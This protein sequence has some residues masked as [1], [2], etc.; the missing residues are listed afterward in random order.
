MLDLWQVTYNFINVVVGAGIV[1]LPWVFVQGGFWLALFE[2]L[3]C[4]ALTDYSVRMLITTG[5]ENGQQNYEDLCFLAFGNAGHF[6]VSLTMTISE[7]PTTTTGRPT[8]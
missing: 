8:E 5:I 4:C 2:M 6:I 1:G 3:L 7:R